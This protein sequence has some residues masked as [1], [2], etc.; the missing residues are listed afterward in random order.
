MQNLFVTTAKTLCPACRQNARGILDRY[1]FLPLLL[2]QGLHLLQRR[3][4]KW[5]A[6]CLPCPLLIWCY[7]EGWIQPYAA[8]ANALVGEQ[9]LEICHAFQNAI[10]PMQ[11]QMQ[12]Y[13]AHQAITW[14]HLDAVAQMLPYHSP[15]I[16]IWMHTCMQLELESH[17]C[18]NIKCIYTKMC[19][20]RQHTQH[21][22]G[23][24]ILL[25]K[26]DSKEQS[27]SC[28]PWDPQHCIL[29]HH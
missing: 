22:C 10:F 6:C 15:F 19:P 4:S 7:P 27:K 1:T 17:T 8:Q 13:I 29:G 5:S 14:F 23:N 9:H 28:Q 21:W 3:L 16:Y 12:K 18:K 11:P 26:M 2:V 24:H 25:T 20:V